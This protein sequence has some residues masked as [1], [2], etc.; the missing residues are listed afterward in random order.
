MN[1]PERNAGIIAM[2][3]KGCHSYGDIAFAFKTSRNAIAGVI[4]RADTL[5]KGKVLGNRIDIAGHVYG[6]WTAIRHFD[7]VN[8]N[9]RWLCRCECGTERPVWLS[10]LRRGLSTHCGCLSKKG[11]TA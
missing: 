5:R 4:N 10:N 1:L 7:R 3:E 2:W 8:D 9:T 11:K 6:S